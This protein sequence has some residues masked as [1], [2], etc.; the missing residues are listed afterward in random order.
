LTS[1]KSH[2]ILDHLA[3]THTDVFPIERPESFSWLC[4]TALFVA[5]CAAGLFAVGLVWWVSSLVPSRSALLL[6]LGHGVSL[7]EA[8]MLFAIIAGY[9]GVK[10]RYRGRVPF[11]NEVPRLIGISCFAFWAE[12]TVG[13]LNH[14][15]TT[16]GATLAVLALF[17]VCAIGANRLMKSGLMQ[18]GLW[19]LPVVII[20]E[21]PTSLAAEAALQSDRSLG[22]KIVGRI[23]PATVMSANTTPRLWPVLNRYGAHRFVLA[24][25]GER[26]ILSGVIDCA[27]RERVP[28]A[29]VPQSYAFPTFSCETTRFFSHDAMLLSFHDGLSRQWLTF[30][31]SVMDVVLALLLLIMASPIFVLVA[32]TNRDG[33]PVFFAHRRVGARGRAFHCLKFRTM[34]VDADKRLHEALAADPALATEWAATHKLANDPRITKVGRF[35]RRTSLDELPQLINVLRREMSLVGPRP[36]VESEVAYYGDNIAHYYGTRPG[37]TGLWQVSGRSKTSYARRVQ[38]DVWYVNNWTVWLDIAVLLKTFRAVVSR[39]GAV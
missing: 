1:L 19:E 10:G 34:V 35:L 5:D 9:L 22:Y 30:T 4:A 21:G 38:L 27:V 33:G 15:L 26:E 36:I 25:D 3:L 20:G 16:R 31:K 32:L 17:P 14:D 8:A 2:Q 11:W 13:I 23:N 12:A 18:L 28:F 6:A 7:Q 37:L 39:D 24:M 29:I